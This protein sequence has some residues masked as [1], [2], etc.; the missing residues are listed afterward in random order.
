MEGSYWPDSSGELHPSQPL[1]EAL[2][3]S[4][5]MQAESAVAVYNSPVAVEMLW[6][7]MASYFEGTAD[8][9][10]CLEELRGKLTLYA[11]E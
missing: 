5:E 4:Y 8:Y 11:K 9:D 2:C 3:E 7:S 6:E 10:T 1:E